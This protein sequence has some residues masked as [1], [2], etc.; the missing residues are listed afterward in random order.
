[1]PEVMAD[2][3]E[4]WVSEKVADGWTEGVGPEVAAVEVGSTFVVQQY[5]DARTGDVLASVWRWQEP[6]RRP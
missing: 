2:N 4:S 1:M 5:T 3:V 6:F